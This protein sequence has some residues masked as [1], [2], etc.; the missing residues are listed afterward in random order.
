MKTLKLPSG[1]EV[2][3]D[4]DDFDRVSQYRWRHQRCANCSYAVSVIDGH[5]VLMHRFILGFP[6]SHIDHSDRNGLN[7]T[8]GNLRLASP[9]QN[10]MNRH[11]RLD[12]K[13]PARG[14]AEKRRGKFTASIAVDGKIEYLGTFDNPVSAALAY[15]SAAISKHGEFASLNYPGLCQRELLIR[16]AEDVGRI[17]A[18]DLV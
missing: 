16:L 18:K 15:D 8:R 14:V 5:R 9:S 2:F 3:L 7:N 1:H 10:A 17:K 13:N 11:R 6:S 12:A 4:D